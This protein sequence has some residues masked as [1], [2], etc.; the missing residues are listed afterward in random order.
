MGTDTVEAVVF[1]ACALIVLGGAFGVIWFRNPV[2]S[3]LSL[4]ATLFGVAVLFLNMNAQFLAAVQVIVY[5]GAIVVLILFVIM[6]LGVDTA[7]DIDAE[8]LV[9]QRVIALVIAAGVAGLVIAGVTIVGGD[10]VSGARAATAAITDDVPNIEQIGRVLFT[11]YV[12]AL[13]ITAVLLTIAVVAAV[14]M[15]RKPTEV[16]PLPQESSSMEPP[17]PVELEAE[18]VFD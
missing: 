2:Q 10:L 16:E 7:D 8:P 17:E 18:E 13:E 4:V 11:D 14:V 1:V 9:G 6:L 12:Y 5:T 15:A 3:A